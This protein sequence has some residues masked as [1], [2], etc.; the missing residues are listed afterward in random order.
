MINFKARFKNPIFIAQII[1][2][3]FTPI[4]AYAGLTMQDMT[5]WGALGNLIVG[6]LSNPYVLGLVV[7]SVWNAI[8]DPTTPTPFDS[9]RALS[10]TAPGIN[11]DEFDDEVEDDFGEDEEE[12]EFDYEE[13]GKADDRE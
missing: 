9:E 12:E 13:M 7:V 11:E 4:L 6:A 8:N 1:L 2:A 5:T 10:Y 3:I